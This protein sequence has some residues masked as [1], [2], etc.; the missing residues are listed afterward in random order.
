MEYETAFRPRGGCF[1]N[2]QT[3]LEAGVRE[4]RNFT[5]SVSPWPSTLLRGGW[6]TFSTV[7]FT[8]KLLAGHRVASLNPDRSP[9]SNCSDL[10]NSEVL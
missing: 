3:A 8:I 7:P 6:L 10:G 1:R 9:D 2:G 5:G 4:M